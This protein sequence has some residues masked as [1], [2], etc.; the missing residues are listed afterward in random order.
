M[1]NRLTVRP[2]ILVAAG[3]LIPGLVLIMI[4]D[5]RLGPGRG[6]SGS[7]E[8]VNAVAPA[9]PVSAPTPA[10]PVIAPPPAEPIQAPAP[11]ILFSLVPEPDGCRWELREMPDLVPALLLVTER[12]PRN[13]LWAGQFGASDLVYSDVGSLVRIDALGRAD[14]LS[15]PAL[16]GGQGYLA[17][18]WIDEESAHLHTGFVS[19]IPCTLAGD[20]CTY[21]LGDRLLRTV[22]EEDGE[23]RFTMEDG[24][25]VP[26]DGD[27]RWLS[28]W[29]GGFVALAFE[30]DPTG[31]W[32]MVSAAPTRTEAA[33][34]PGFSIL[35]VTE[36]PGTV[37]LSQLREATTCLWHRIASTGCV[38]HTGT[39]PEWFARGPATTAD[40]VGS[41]SVDGD[42]WVFPMRWGDTPHAFGPIFLDC[43]PE[44][45]S[46]PLNLATLSSAQ[47]SLSG[48]GHYLL[49]GREYSL[50]GGTVFIAGSSEPILTLPE[51][52]TSVWLP[53]SEN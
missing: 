33:G 1:S 10:A 34:A 38:E 45:E 47:L 4:V 8:T 51:E 13:I 46:Q 7:T 2:T 40:E 52:A 29:G 36:A 18:F 26:T 23:E 48:S 16:P 50:T 19:G 41:I 27:S 6:G 44:C 53:V 37:T 35:N 17:K 3:I 32:T 22:I 49:V 39:L 9:R 12:C 42:T 11:A 30:L 25:A 31:G 21:D 15:L 24:W 43:G 20:Q 14:T 28:K 5:R